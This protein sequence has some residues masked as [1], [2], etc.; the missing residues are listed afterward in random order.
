MNTLPQSKIK[1]WVV[2]LVVLP[3]FLGCKTVPISD[4]H[5][6][7]K[8]GFWEQDQNID[9]HFYHNAYDKDETIGLMYAS[10]PGVL[11]NGSPTKHVTK[12]DN[13]SFVSTA[14]RSSA[15]IEFKSGSKDCLVQVNE[16][17]FGNAYV[18][19]ADCHYQI[20]TIHAVIHA[21]NAIMHV[22]TLQ[23]QT[24][25]TVLSGV[26]KIMSQKNP[27]EL[28]DLNEMREVIVT[29]EAISR[30]RLLKPDEIRQRL[31]WRENHVFYEKVIDWNKVAA[32]AATV[33]I[34][35]VAILAPR[36]M[37]GGRMYGGRH[38]WR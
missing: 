30:P 17:Y 4:R 5:V 1:L 6:S 14:P 32:V 18:D 2:L 38:G 26:I 10:S 3:V 34:I 22:N 20:D 27:T 9:S 8:G 31:R 24:T 21:K 15:R 29:H 7:E 11:L 23:Q 12:I 36:T 19:T 35:A 28:I 13:H 37:R 33:A 25:V 16:F